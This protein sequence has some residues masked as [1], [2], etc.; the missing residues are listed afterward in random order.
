VLVAAGPLL[1]A[2][3]GRGGPGSA[4][5]LA[6][7]ASPFTPP[8]VVTA[9]ERAE[10]CADAPR[11]DLANHP[12]SRN[13]QGAQV[14]RIPRIEVAL[15]QQKVGLKHSDLFARLLQSNSNLQ[16]NHTQHNRNKDVPQPGTL[17][18][19]GSVRAAAIHAFQA[20]GAHRSLRF[21]IE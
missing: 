15:S 10:P 16:R 6:A 19:F 9:P 12:L 11:D 17:A 8:L 2:S 4:A 7:L 18:V 14:F 3:A 5:L 13:S 21:A 1:G 20:T